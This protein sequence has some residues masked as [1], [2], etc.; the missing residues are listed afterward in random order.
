MLAAYATDIDRENPLRG[1]EIGDR[2]DPEVPAGFTTVTVRAASLNHHDLWSLRGVGLSREALPMILGCDAAGVDEQG[3]EVVVHSVITSDSWLG[4]ETLDPRRSILSERHQGTF[5][6]RVAAPRRNLV[7][8]PPELSFE[9]A[10]CLPTAWLTAY[11][12]LFTR[13][14]LLPGTTVLVQGATGGVS[15][16]MISLGSAAGI[17]VWVTSRA[18][19]KRAEAL[20]LGAD[21][22]FEPG[23]RLP[24]RVDAVMETVGEATWAHSVR[25]LKPGGTIVV[26]GTTSGDAP[27]AELR[28]IFFLQLSVVGSTMGTR[29]EL[30][31]LIQLCVRQGVR[32][33]IQMT[34]PLGDA[35]DG[36]EAMLGGEVHGKI[37]FTP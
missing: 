18:E 27:P 22:A 12:M 21:Q 26:A 37:V 29:E 10:A 30:E 7:A 8:K 9:E 31:R 13:A 17:R 5:A 24:E 36:F 19:A 1:L 2:P 28:R 32:P 34:L 11:R 6:E 4:D 33:V 25:A 23:A 14:K 16:A 35:R 15:T 3:N 20:E